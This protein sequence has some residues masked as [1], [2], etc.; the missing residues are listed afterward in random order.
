MVMVALISVTVTAD[1]DE[2]LEA[3]CSSDLLVPS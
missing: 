3:F 2:V 1:A